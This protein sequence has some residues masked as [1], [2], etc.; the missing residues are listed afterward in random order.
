MSA[1]G[2]Q[3]SA[4]SFS[5][6]CAYQWLL[7]SDGDGGRGLAVG[8]I[9]VESV[10]GG[11]RRM[12]S[13]GGAAGGADF[14][15]KDDVGR[16]GRLPRKCDWGASGYGGCACI[17]LG[18]SWRGTAWNVA[19]GKERS[20]F[21]DVKVGSRDGAE[22]VKVVVAPAIVGRATDVHR[23]AIIGHDDAVLL[24]SVENY[25]IGGAEI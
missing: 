8:V 25:L 23:R 22:S 17:Q 21:E 5:G 7:D 4:D 16:A 18:N 10:G 15:G 19:R 13:R 9:G 3:A 2:A 14:G 20:D 11:G 24:H 12:D 6:V 1:E